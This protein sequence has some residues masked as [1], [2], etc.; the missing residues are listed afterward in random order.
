MSTQINL[1]D[2]NPA[3]PAGKTNVKW[4]AVPEPVV[5]N[6]VAVSNYGGA[7]QIG[8]GAPH[9]LVTGD[10]VYVY[11]PNFLAI[12]GNWKVT[13]INT[14]TL[15]LQGSTYSTGWTSL[16]AATILAARD[17]SAYMPVM[18]GDTGTGG[19][20]GAVPAPP[21]GSAAAGKFLEA[22]GTW[23]IPAG[24]GG[25]GVNAQ[26]V[27]YTAQPTD[28]GKLIAMNS[29]LG[30]TLAMPATSPGPT[31]WIMVENIG[32]SV[33]T[34]DPSSL[35]LDNRAQTLALTQNTGIAIF[36]DGSNYF[37]M[38]GRPSGQPYDVNFSY[39]GSLPGVV[40]VPLA[41]FTRQVTFPANFAGSQGSC[42]TNPTASAVFQL[43][44]N[45]GACGSVTISTGGLFT[46]TSG[47][48]AFQIGDI[49]QVVTPA[50]DATLAGVGFTL[51]GMRS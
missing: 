45:G 40:T 35:L 33:V 22:N 12:A 38:R 46:F 17:V 27:S 13:A 48:L 25:G 1:N 51:A 16:F 10:S 37:T 50:V 43:L 14:T 28:A 5:I 44:K 15:V 24:G 19:A 26:S 41:N 31:W 49:L 9:G 8:G 6:V 3:A 21:A 4:Q 42:T 7:F 32:S 2:S 18:V 36:C 30:L 11:S 20:S 23:A 29:S 34:V 47:A 39:P